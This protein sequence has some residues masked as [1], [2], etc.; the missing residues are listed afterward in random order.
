MNLS[1]EGVGR[2]LRYFDIASSEML[3]VYDELDLRPGVLRLKRGGSAGGHRGVESILQHVEDK[4]VRL[5]VGIGHPRDI[6]SPMDVSS[7]VL[8]EPTK[9]EQGLLERAVRDATGA[10]ELLHAQGMEAAQTKFHK[11][12]Q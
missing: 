10:I 4:F 9:E 3:V 1:G 5:R 12:N 11:P 2:Y 6:Q 8:A 7:W